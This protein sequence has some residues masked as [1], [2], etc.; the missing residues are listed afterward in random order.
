MKKGSRSIMSNNSKLLIYKSPS[1]NFKIDVR[2]EN[3]TVWLTQKLMT[4]LFQI[5]PQNITRYLKNIYDEGELDEKATC[6]DYLQVQNEAK[7]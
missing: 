3:K 4:E 1:G 6:K 7:I 5:K 2:L